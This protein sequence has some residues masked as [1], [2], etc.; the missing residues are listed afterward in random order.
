MVMQYIDIG[1]FKNKLRRTC[2]KKN[3]HNLYSV[4]KE[5]K[6][7]YGGTLQAMGNFSLMLTSGVTFSKSF[8]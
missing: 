2:W 4:L 1:F 8:E 6:V 5:R 7:R 3:F